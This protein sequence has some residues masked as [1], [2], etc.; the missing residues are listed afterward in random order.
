[1]NYLADL[2]FKDFYIFPI[3]FIVILLWLLIAPWFN[4]VLYVIGV[5]GFFSVTT[6]F[7]AVKTLSNYYKG[8][9]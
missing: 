8:T 1:M 7:S 6:F 5:L 4:Y 9:K 3:G 2:W